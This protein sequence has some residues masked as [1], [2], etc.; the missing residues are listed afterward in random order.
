MSIATNRALIHELQERI[1]KIAGGSAKKRG[2][3]PFGVPE[4]DDRLPGGGLAFGALHEIAGGGSDAVVG[5]VSAL[6]A[7]SIAARTKGTVVW[8][9]TRPDLFA[10][11]LA[12]VGLHPDRVIYCESDNEDGVLASMEE[13]L[14]F[15]G[16]STVVGELVRLPMTESRRLNLAA[17]KTGVMGIV[18]RRWRRPAEATDFGNPT[19]SSTRWRVSCLPSEPLPVEGVGRPRWLLELLRAKAG[20]SFDIAVGA[21]DLK[22]RLASIS[23]DPDQGDMGDLKW[24]RM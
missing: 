21:P 11:G 13:A 24:S 1:D 14:S 19:A 12:Q 10:P 2:T 4:I 23:R 15:G 17:E 5:A 18:I 20:E 8:C 6:F 3:L 22:G 7:A 16:L 9:L